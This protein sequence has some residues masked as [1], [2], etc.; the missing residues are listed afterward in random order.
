MERTPGGLLYVDPETRD[1]LLQP[2]QRP[3]FVNPRGVPSFSTGRRVTVKLASDYFVT[4]AEA[5]LVELHDAA[6]LL[7]T[8]ELVEP[9]PLIPLLEE[10]ARAARPIA[11]GTPAISADALVFLVANKLRGILHCAAFELGPL[12][13]DGLA[14][15][16]GA[17]G[18]LADPAGHAL[19]TLPRAR[20]VVLSPDALSIDP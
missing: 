15:F 19:A 10:C 2:T 7:T 4:D 6:L 18:A 16:A 14:R 13:L 12:Q 1:E 5:W 3:P 9:T 8:A 11:I 17:T 20:R